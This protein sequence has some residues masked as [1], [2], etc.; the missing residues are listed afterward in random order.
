VRTA[1]LAQRWR[2]KENAPVGMR[3]SDDTR[4]MAVARLRSGLT[5][6][7][8]GLDTFIRRVDD[9]YRAKTRDELWHLTRDLPEHRWH[10]R[11][12]NWLRGTGATDGDTPQQHL[13]PPSIGPGEALTLGR[14]SDCDYV[15][16]SVAVSA[17]HARLRRDPDGW[18]LRDLGSR[19][20]T[21]VNG[22]LITEQPL[23][24]GD[25]VTLGDEHFVFRAPA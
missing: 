8:V 12:A 11:V 24:D 13:S 23:T 15:V 7:R 17:R 21:R 22:W 3:A 2:R 6:G 14:G 20:G 25:E 19:N 5:T 4:E 1:S 10:R 16:A 18:T 9:A